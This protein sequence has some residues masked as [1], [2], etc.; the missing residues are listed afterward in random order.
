MGDQNLYCAIRRWEQKN[1][2]KFYE[3]IIR[4]P[5]LQS[6]N[7]MQTVEIRVCISTS[8][9][10]IESSSELDF[11]YEG[12]NEINKQQQHQT[13]RTCGMIKQVQGS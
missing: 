1:Q 3:T 6:S 9:I 4:Y 2:Y 5:V 7:Q 11:H 12:N 10:Y 13:A 8:S